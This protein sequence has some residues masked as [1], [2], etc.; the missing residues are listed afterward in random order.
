MLRH[1]SDLNTQISLFGGVPLRPVR[2]VAPL[3][4]K[5]DPISSQLAAVQI[6]S[7]GQLTSQKAEILCWLRA[8]S[9]PLTSMEIAHA[10]GLDRY[11]VAR[12]LPDPER[13]GLVERCAIRECSASNRAAIIGRIQ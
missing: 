7:S 3:A 5:N 1:D 8:Q 6:T 2:E 12:R 9:Q 11:M 10:A 4:A 13:E